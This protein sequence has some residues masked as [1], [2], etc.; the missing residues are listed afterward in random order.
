MLR[1]G[2]GRVLAY[3]FRCPNNFLG[4][5]GTERPELR[6]V[7]RVC[8]V[9]KGRVGEQVAIL[10]LQVIHLGA[11][12]FAERVKKVGH[13]HS[14]RVRLDKVRL[15]IGAL[16]QSICTAKACCGAELWNNI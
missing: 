7:L 10:R 2:C 3:S 15:S 14:L 16:G 6:N 12:V 13:C 1:R 4:N 5:V 8:I 11:V 9:L